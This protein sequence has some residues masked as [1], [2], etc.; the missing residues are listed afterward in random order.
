MGKKVPPR[1]WKQTSELITHEP[2]DKA[3]SEIAIRTTWTVDVIHE[4]LFESK[5]LIRLEDARYHIYRDCL[6]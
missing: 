6:G 3:I 4:K 1:I 2:V 5:N